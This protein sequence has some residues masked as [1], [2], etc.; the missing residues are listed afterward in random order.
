MIYRI[1]SKYIALILLGTVF[2]MSSYKSNTNYTKE[3]ELKTIADNLVVSSGSEEAVVLN[4]M[5]TENQNL[6][7][8]D[9][10]GIDSVNEVDNVV[11][12]MNTYLLDNPR[13]FINTDEMYICITFYDEEP[14]GD[15][16]NIQEYFAQ[17]GNYPFEAGYI[18]QDTDR[19]DSI[20]RIQIYTTAV[21]PISDFSKCETLF[22]R[23]VVSQAVVPDNIDSIKKIKGLESISLCEIS[24]YK[25]NALSYENYA[26]YCNAFNEINQEKGYMFATI[27]VNEVSLQR[28]EEEYG[29]EFIVLE[30]V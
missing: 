7:K 18:T 23:I 30:A 27:S 5:V 3:K 4:T 1:I 15:L 21:F 17:A 25:M 2:S 24:S 16:V 29:E 19:D 11:S 14:A 8:I 6:V 10:L 12:A 20:D 13:C 22:K 9:M 26:S 28:W